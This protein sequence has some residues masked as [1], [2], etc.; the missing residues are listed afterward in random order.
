M[1]KLENLKGKDKKKIVPE[2]IDRFKR[3]IKGHEKLLSSI[4]N[5]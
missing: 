4:G 2:E 5:L 1:E 3:L